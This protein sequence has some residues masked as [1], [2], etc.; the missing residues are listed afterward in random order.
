MEKYPQQGNGSTT[1]YPPFP[2]FSVTNSW[3]VVHFSFPTFGGAFRN[4]E[5]LIF[6]NL[7]MCFSKRL[8]KD[9]NIQKQQTYGYHSMIY[10]LEFVDWL[11]S[12]VFSSIVLVFF[13][14]HK[15][16]NKHKNAFL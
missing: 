7:S 2:S 10:F 5:V 16:K 6:I 1:F 8:L 12:T 15:I 3:L 9:A 11:L 13:Q 14:H 4:H